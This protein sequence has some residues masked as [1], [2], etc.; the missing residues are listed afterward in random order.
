MKKA[1]KIF[2][3]LSLSTAMALGLTSCAC[4]RIIEDAASTAADLTHDLED[5]FSALQEGSSSET[6]G[7]SWDEGSESGS[8]EGGSSSS[9]GAAAKRSDSLPV[10][11]HYDKTNFEALC[12][13]LTEAAQG[14]D[15]S[16]LKAAYEAALEA[17]GEISDLSIV[18]ELNYDDDPTDAS[19]KEEHT[20]SSNLLTE[21]CDLLLT[22]GNQAARGP[23]AEDFRDMVTEER[24]EDFAD[25]EPM[26]EEEKAASER[27]VELTTEYQA[28][29]EAYDRDELDITEL[30]QKAGAIFLELVKLRTEEAKA[31]GYDS[32]V[33]YAD[34]LIYGRSYGTAE[35]DQLH[36]LAK[37]IAPTYYKLLYHSGISNDIQ[38]VGEELSG[39]ELVSILCQ[40][41]GKID[42]LAGEAASTLS[43]NVLY[44]ID[45]D[46][47]RIDGGYTTRFYQCGL[48]YIYITTLGNS[49]ADI[50]SLTHEFGH[51]T[52][53][54][55]NKLTDPLSAEL[56]NLDILESHS[57][58][59]QQLFTAYYGDIFGKDAGTVISYNLLDA[60]GNLIS[61]CLYDEFQREVYKNPDMTLDQVNKLYQRLCEEYGD[62][63]TGP[64]D[65]FWVLIP[66]TFQSPMYYFSY[67]V[68]AVSALEI[69]DMS[70]KD[71]DS[72]VTA[73]RTLIEKFDASASY[74]DMMTAA[75]LKPFTD[76]ESVKAACETAFSVMADYGYDAEAIEEDPFGG[77]FKQD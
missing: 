39:E 52:D 47:T 34:E 26:T 72:A 30:D 67:A 19:L 4:S 23:L 70:Q 33:E 24:F 56:V 7:I 73:W 29:C 15:A 41:A 49:A 20:Y 60:M 2:L 13:A 77:L 8:S 57:N 59:F 54:T 58:G 18:A 75:G 11:Y 71:R 55:V 27:A 14:Q 45:D 63:Y 5:S 6:D 1:L 32:Y 48:P 53:F 16:A 65:Y 28:L 61:G 35:A 69:F 51:F 37:E 74:E 40:Y 62:E 9:E 25:Y 10:Y 43:E 44:D 36:A 50:P 68:S 12:A 66:H 17:Y 22:A 38:N 46:P 21:A 76:T 42:T 64:T 31:E 3:T